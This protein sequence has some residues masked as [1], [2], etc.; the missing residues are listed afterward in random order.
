MAPV[1]ENE[2]KVAIRPTVAGPGQFVNDY[3]QFLFL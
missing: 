1:A 2:A 3:S